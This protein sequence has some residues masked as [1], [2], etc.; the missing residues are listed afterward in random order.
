[1]KTDSA[2]AGK[3]TAGGQ[4]PKQKMVMPGFRE[5]VQT[6]LDDMLA[7]RP[8]VRRGAMFGMP[9]YFTGRK[10][11]VCCFDEGIG[12]KLPIGRV[13]ELQAND[14]EIHPHAPGGRLMKEWVYIVRADLD[15]FR[16]DQELLDESI[17]FVSGAE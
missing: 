2:K 12:L 6:M 16:G 10:M 15:D 5:D 4:A 9:G 8:D 1:M 13:A 7:N 3:P 17:A 14:V 11:F